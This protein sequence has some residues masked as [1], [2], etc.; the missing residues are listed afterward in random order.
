[1][2][3]SQFFSLKERDTFT[4]IS[5]EGNGE[6]RWMVTGTDGGDMIDAQCIDALAYPTVPEVFYASQARH[7]TFTGPGYTSEH[8]RRQTAIRDFQTYCRAHP[9]F[10]RI[11]HR[12][13]SP[14]IC[15]WVAQSTH[16]DVIRPDHTVI[17]Y[18]VDAREEVA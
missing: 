15:R 13:V 9:S 1:M 18:V 16:I 8:A 6:S 17:S 7:M 4:F 5:P 14:M 11:A 10:Q 12:I 2:Q 3:A